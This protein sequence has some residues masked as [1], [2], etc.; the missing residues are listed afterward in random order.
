MGGTDLDQMLMGGS[1]AH[2]ANAT[3]FRIDTPLEPVV[4]G[5][6]RLQSIDLFAEVSFDRAG[7]GPLFRVSSAPPR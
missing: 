6:A 1:G 2:Y 3:S 4:Q 5:Y 7:S